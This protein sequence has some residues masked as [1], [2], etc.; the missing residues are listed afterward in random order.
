MTQVSAVVN[1]ENSCSSDILTSAALLREAAELGSMKKGYGTDI[2][3]ITSLTV[4]GLDRLHASIAVGDFGGAGDLE[5]C[6]SAVESGRLLSEMA[7]T[8]I[9]RNIRR[10]AVDRSTAPLA[11]AALTAAARTNETTVLDIA[12]SIDNLANTVCELPAEFL[13]D[14]A[15][16]S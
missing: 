2:D 1:I 9:A 15:R 8:H 14:G 16:Q 5:Q 11:L 10:L 3:Y 7:R 6:A 4:Q 12:R 13:R